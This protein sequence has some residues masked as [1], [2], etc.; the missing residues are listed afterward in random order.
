[1]PNRQLTLRIYEFIKRYLAANNE[2]PTIREIRGYFDISSP[3]SVFYHLEK[4]EAGG[5][6][7]KIPNISRGIRL[8]EK[9]KH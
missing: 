6:I 9:A 1:M 3:A 8:V 4:M 7:T 5:L 2:P